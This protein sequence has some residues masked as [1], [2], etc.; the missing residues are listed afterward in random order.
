VVKR[1]DG[2]M[3]GGFI[4]SGDAPKKV[5]IRAIG[6]SLVRAGVKGALMDP[7]LEL[8]ASDGTLIASNDNWES[9]STEVAATG[10]S[11]IDNRESAIVSTLAPGAYT[12][13]VRGANDT[14]GEALVELYDLSRETSQ[15]A[16][17]ST[18]AEIDG[19]EHPLIG[20]FIVGADST[21]KLLIRA[22]G[23]SLATSSFSSVLSN[24]T[25]S[26]Y[27]SD[28]SIL[29]QNDDWRSGQNQEVLDSGLAPANDKEA[30][31]IASLSA[32]N[33]TAVVNG[34]SGGS[35]VGLVEIYNLSH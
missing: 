22:L 30:A 11:P 5:I 1:G 28:G 2:V 33:Y 16:N 35:G 18:R 4:I 13:V 25:L 14:S 19:N 6:P 32:G 10:V 24:P 17:I 23:P 3:I 27:N 8:H 15:I 34:V 12:A 21:S 20:G 29:Y 9:N 7:I 26:L 31:I